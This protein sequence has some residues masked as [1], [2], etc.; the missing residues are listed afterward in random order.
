MTGASRFQHANGR[1]L[2]VQDRENRS[3]RKHGEKK[4]RRRVVAFGRAEHEYGAGPHEVIEGIDVP[5]AVR[6]LGDPRDRDSGVSTVATFEVQ[7]GRP[8]ARRV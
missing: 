4:L 3:P 2:R 6:V 8:G 1:A 5:N 7:A